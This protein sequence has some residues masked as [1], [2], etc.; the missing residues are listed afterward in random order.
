M[1]RKEMTVMA[2]ETGRATYG[3]SARLHFLNDTTAFD[4]RLCNPRLLTVTTANMLN[5]G[6]VPTISSIRSRV[7]QTGQ[8]FPKDRVLEGREC[9]EAEKGQ[10]SRTKR[11][12]QSYHGIHQFSSTSI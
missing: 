3:P 9:R 2:K 12:N 5:K 6:D 7:L 8:W 4:T 11:F 10:E 1:S